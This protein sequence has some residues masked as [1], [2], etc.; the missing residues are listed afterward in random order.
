MI[1]RELKHEISWQLCGSY[2]FTNEQNILH[3]IRFAA[4]R[5][6]YIIPINRDWFYYTSYF[7]YV[8]YS[9]RH[10]ERKNR[11]KA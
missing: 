11:Q 4:E 2:K 10:V 3:D 1:S 8:I 7:L 9:R 5:L 6:L